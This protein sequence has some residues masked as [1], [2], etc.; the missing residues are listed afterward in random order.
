MNVPENLND[1]SLEEAKKLTIVWESEIGD[2]TEARDKATSMKDMIEA[3]EKLAE[4]KAKKVELDELIVKAEEVVAEDTTPDGNDDDDEKNEGKEAEGNDT[5]PAPEPAVEPDQEITPEPNPDVE[6][7]VDG[8]EEV[9][10]EAEK[11]VADVAPVAEAEVIAERTPEVVAASLDTGV[12]VDDVNEPTESVTPK[13]DIVASFETI[14]DGAKN[15][16]EAIAKVVARPQGGDAFKTVLDNK[17]V[18]AAE[19]SPA[20]QTDF[21]MSLETPGREGEYTRH[22]KQWLLA[23]AQKDESLRGRQLDEVAAA[24]CQPPQLLDSDIT[25][26]SYNPVIFNSLPSFLMEDG[27]EVEVYVPIDS[28]DEDFVGEVDLYSAGGGALVNGPAEKAC[29]ELDC[30]TRTEFP[31]KEVKAC[32]TANEQTA[33][34]APRAVQGLLSDGTARL[35]AT[36]DQIIL[37]WIAEETYKFA[38]AAQDAGYAEVPLALTIAME[39][40]NRQSQITQV[41]DLVAYIPFSFLNYAVADQHLAQFSAGAATARQAALDLVTSIGIR[42]VVVYDDTLDSGDSRPVATLSKTSDTTITA[43]TANTGAR[44]DWDIHL[45]NP[46]EAF[47]GLRNENEYSLQEV[48]P[49]ITERRN[50]RKSWFARNYF[51]PGRR[52]CDGWAT[53]SFSNLCLG[54]R[55]VAAQTCLATS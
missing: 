38:Y 31:V 33:F 51:T 15:E 7:P 6:K 9:V 41:S 5:E 50:N 47:V 22:Q 34:T 16:G 12:K 1:L 43:A 26:G 24:L 13:M 45:I 20:E 54:G 27:L 19:T 2:L 21:I 32:L 48:A 4:L 18:I 35:A 11:I 3:R 23:Q 10:A 17:R 8:Q 49:S 37:D 36:R 40:L 39:H 30:V 53:V 44:N 52:G 55:V 28:S 46:A 25:C 42:D 14:V 29:Y